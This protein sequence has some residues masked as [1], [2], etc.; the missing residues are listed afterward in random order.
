VQFGVWSI[1]SPIALSIAS[2][3]RVKWVIV[4][5]ASFVAVLSLRPLPLRFFHSVRLRMMPAR[6][7]CNSHSRRIA[8]DGGAH[9]FG[10]N[11]PAYSQ[12]RAAS[13]LSVLLCKGRDLI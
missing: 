3:W 13:T 12:I 9:G 7:V 6:T 5:A 1:V 2:S 8:G 10:L 11:N 4:A